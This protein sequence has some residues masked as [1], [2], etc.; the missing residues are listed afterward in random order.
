MDKETKLHLKTT[1]IRSDILGRALINQTENIQK[2]V[3]GRNTLGKISINYTL[4]FGS[5]GYVTYLFKFL[6]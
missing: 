4:E 2:R 6:T 5:P 3:D 1:L